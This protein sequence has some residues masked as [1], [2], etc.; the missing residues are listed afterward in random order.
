MQLFGWFRAGEAEA[1]ARE[2]AAFMAAE[3]KGRLGELDAKG[4]KKAEKSMARADR[5]VQDFRAK[6]RLNFFQ[7]SKL[8][9]RF[10]WSLKEAGWPD[11]YARQMTDWLTT[12]L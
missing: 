6:H 2:L 10:L 11:P 1:F 8:A 5:K 12:R 7:K 3:F 9:N 4:R